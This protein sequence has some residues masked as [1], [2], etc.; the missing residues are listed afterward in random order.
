MKSQGGHWLENGGF[1]VQSGI[2]RTETQIQTYSNSPAL[3]GR[4]DPWTFS[5]S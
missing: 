1:P 2:L 5:Q 3:T 4:Y